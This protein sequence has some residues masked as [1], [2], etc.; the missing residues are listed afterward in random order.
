MSRVPPVRRASLARVPALA[1]YA[2][3]AHLETALA[4]REA[5][6]VPAAVRRR[7][8]F[9]VTLANAH[10]ALAREAADLHDPR[11]V[12]EEAE[13]L[14]RIMAELDASRADLASAPPPRAPALTSALSAF[15]SRSRRRIRG[16][17]SAP[18]TQIPQRR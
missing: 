3:D 11:I 16:A 15:D 2:L 14:Q 10:V 1:G 17:A 4:D 12:T 6:R 7:G 5:R 13:W 8:Q 9:A 18:G